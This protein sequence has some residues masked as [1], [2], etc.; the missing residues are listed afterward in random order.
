[1]LVCQK[2][3]LEAW[4]EIE[5]HFFFLIYSLWFLR[6]CL[7]LFTERLAQHQ[8]IPFLNLVQTL[9]VRFSAADASDTKLGGKRSSPSSST[10]RATSV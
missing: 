4:F 8:G 5:K 2:L 6:R 3:S 7:I 9:P 10:P 1:M